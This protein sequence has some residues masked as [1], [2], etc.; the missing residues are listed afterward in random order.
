MPSRVHCLHHGRTLCGLDG[1]PSTW[2]ANEWWLSKADW[3]HTNEQLAELA[4]R[5]GMVCFACD[6]KA[7]ELPDDR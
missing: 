4:Q 5:N 7:K 3:P 2:P 6:L 1:M